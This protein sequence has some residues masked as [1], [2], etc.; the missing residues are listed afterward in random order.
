MFR[1]SDEEGCHSSVFKGEELCLVG[2][3]PCLPTD[4][5][6]KNIMKYI[7]YTRRVKE[8]DMIIILQNWI[9]K[10]TNAGLVSLE[11]NRHCRKFIRGLKEIPLSE[12]LQ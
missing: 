7:H 6:L 5:P 12:E 4:L 10:T 2:N 1:C 9:L 11:L 8:V 3:H